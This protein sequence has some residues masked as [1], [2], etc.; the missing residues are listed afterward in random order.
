MSK[1]VDKYQGDGLEVL[2]F[3]CDQFGGQELPTKDIAAFC[4]SKGYSDKIRLMDKVS[5]N[6]PNTAAV[7]KALKGAGCTGCESDIGWNFKR[8]YLVSRTGVVE[9]SEERD[10]MKMEGRIQELLAE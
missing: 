1:L 6:G 4:K 3:P 7:Y 2:A 5:V 10:P 8:K 9:A